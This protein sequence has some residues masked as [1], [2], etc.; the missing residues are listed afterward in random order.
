MC[1]KYLRYKHKRN[2]TILG[3]L[4]LFI[5]NQYLY[6][7]GFESGTSKS[8]VKHANNNHYSHSVVFIN[9]ITDIISAIYY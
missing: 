1:I 8:Q 7:T 9:G 4:F 5:Y 6:P 2:N 3:Y